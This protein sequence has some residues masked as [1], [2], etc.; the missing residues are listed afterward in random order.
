[1]CERCVCEVCVCERYVCEVCVCGVC[2]C[3]VCRAED[4]GWYEIDTFPTLYGINCI[5]S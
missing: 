2:V 1:M 5:K 4:G 3:G